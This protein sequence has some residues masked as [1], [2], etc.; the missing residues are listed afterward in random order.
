MACLALISV[1]EKNGLEEL[2][3]GLQY[4]G[5]K[6]IS[7]GCTAKA[8]REAG[9]EVM[10]VAAVSYTHLRAHETSLPI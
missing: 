4:L 10:E 5:W 2:G 8:L 1:S 9:C 6:L 3:C 7:T